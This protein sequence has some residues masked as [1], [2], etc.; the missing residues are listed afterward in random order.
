[1]ARG[2]PSFRIRDI[3]D[4]IAKSLVARVRELK[5]GK[6]NDEGTILGFLILNRAAEKSSRA[7]ARCCG[8]WS[9]NSCRWKHR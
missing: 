2:A 3:H 6:G 4:A 9:S 7:C 8:E 1:M 5:H